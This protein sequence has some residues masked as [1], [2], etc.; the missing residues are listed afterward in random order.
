MQSK[1]MNYFKVIAS[2]L[3]ISPNSMALHIIE[4]IIIKDLKKGYHALLK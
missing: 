1:D 3:N 2:Q 4:D